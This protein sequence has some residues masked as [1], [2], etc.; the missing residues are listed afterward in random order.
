VNTILVMAPF[1]SKRILL[2]TNV[3]SGELNVFLAVAQ[4]MRDAD[5]TVDLHLATTP[6]FQ[7]D[8]PEGATYHQINGIPVMQAVKDRFNHQQDGVNLPMSFAKP[9]GFSNTRRAI[10]DAA[11]VFMPYTGR[12]MVDL[13]TSVVNIINEV[14]PDLVVVNSL[15]AAGLTAC[16][17]LDVKFI[18]LSPN[19]IKEFAASEQ[20]RA[21]G[22]WKFPA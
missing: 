17:H 14:Q 16:Y 11:A 19:S 10:R 6:G 2:I 8:V 15:M 1:R 20:P 21:A 4:S 22:F 5:I 7:D 3:E 9:P 12:Q 18:C 13:F